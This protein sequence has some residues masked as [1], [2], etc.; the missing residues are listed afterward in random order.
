MNNSSLNSQLIREFKNGSH[1]AFKEIYL[2]YYEDLC[3]YACN[4]TND[5]YT[6]EDLVQN[7]LLKF[8]E[9]KETINIG[10][11]L[12]NYLYKS[13]YNAF[14]DN[15]RKE[16]KLKEKLETLR[17]NLLNDIIEEDSELLDK[18]LAILREGI[19]ELPKKCKKIFLLSKFEGMSYKQIAETL[20][21]SVNTVENQIGKAFKMLRMK[22]EEYKNLNLF[23][24][25]SHLQKII[26]YCVNKV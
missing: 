15:F 13:V 20:N 2:T 3:I 12:K 26:N 14:I 9:N 1:D 21:I 24:S 19:E 10:I 6:A 5:H 22:S 11:N 23:I 8:W 4:Y 7:L 25:F 18:R 17:Y 16:K